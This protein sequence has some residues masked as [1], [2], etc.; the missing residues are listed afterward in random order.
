MHEALA[1]LFKRTG[2]AVLSAVVALREAWLRWKQAIQDGWRSFMTSNSWFQRASAW[3]SGGR[4]LR[5]PGR[6]STPKTPTVLGVVVL[7]SSFGLH[8]DQAIARLVAW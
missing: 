4:Q 8:E 7:E 3:F 6:G 5:R 2:Y 1:R